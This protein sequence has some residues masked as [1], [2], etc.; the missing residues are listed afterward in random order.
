MTPRLIDVHVYNFIKVDTSYTLLCIIVLVMGAQ[1]NA[2]PLWRAAYEPCRLL[3][4]F[5][6]AASR[7]LL[8]TDGAVFTGK[9]TS[10]FRQCEQ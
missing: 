1:P 8:R 2:M 4:K 10:G 9:V 7:T 5:A 3:Q 6:P